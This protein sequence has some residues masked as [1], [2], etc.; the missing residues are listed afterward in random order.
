LSAGICCV[1]VDEL[2][3][4]A[5][6]S[7]HSSSTLRTTL[8]GALWLSV[9]PLMLN[10][11]SIPVMAYIIHRLGPDGYGQWMTA[12]S[13]V[14]VCAIVTNLGLRGAFVR[15]IAADPTV[16]VSALA[17]QLGLRLALSLLAAACATAACLLLGYPSSVLWCTIIGGVGLGLMTIATTLADLLQSLHRLKTLA[18]VNLLSGLMLT[19]G[20][21]VAARFH[22]GP[23]TMALAYLSGTLFGVLLL[24]TL[25]QKQGCPVTFRYDIR[26]FARLL[27]RSRFFAAQQLLATG[28]AQAEA[29]LLPRL[30]GMSQFGFFT[31][32][33]LMATRLT[34]LPDGL[35]T[36]AY[37]AMVRAYAGSA[38]RGARLAAQ[39][40]LIVAS[41]GVVLALLGGLVAEP[42]G[43]LLFPAAPALFAVVARI[44]VWSLPLL[45]IEMVMGY[46]LNAAGE[47]AAQA[48]V[49]APAAII[50]LVASAGLVLTFGVYGACWSM[51]VR[52]AVRAAFLTPLFVRQFRSRTTADPLPLELE[53]SASAAGTLVY[54]KVA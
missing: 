29:L 53:L 40:L 42:I 12:A 3:I 14:A 35:C 52:P 1:D 22:A 9:Q 34:V 4:R 26:R 46:A 15:T 32:G 23:V 20:S 44:T 13:L 43:K 37:P 47:D 41:G 7:K 31:A 54:R 2:M 17:E 30:V 49:S 6:S 21:F 8:V 11:L 50:S 10:V 48:R 18:V 5:A 16:A 19:G 27:G 25:V 39:Y 38:R 51:L 36:A 28:S 24:A 33:T 45:G